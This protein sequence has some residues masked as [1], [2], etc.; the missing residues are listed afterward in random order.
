MNLGSA[1]QVTLAN[2]TLTNPMWVSAADNPALWV[3]QWNLTQPFGNAQSVFQTAQIGVVPDG[4][5][6]VIEHYNVTC[7]V[8]NG[9]VLADVAVIVG[10]SCCIRDDATPHRL[11]AGQTE[12]GWTGNNTTRIYGNGGET[13]S[14]GAVA[15]GGKLDGCFGEVHGYGVKLQ[16]GS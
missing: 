16:A 8:D 11:G 12:T 9:G 13:V 4:W 6:Y 15:N 7:E 14:L 1:S 10:Q 5:R 2:N 3:F